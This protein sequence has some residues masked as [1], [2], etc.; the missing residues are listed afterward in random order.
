MARLLRTPQRGVHRRRA[1]LMARLL[2]TPQ[3]GV[4]RR[5]AGHVDGLQVAWNS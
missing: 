2:R 1:G 3:R 5:R 4:H